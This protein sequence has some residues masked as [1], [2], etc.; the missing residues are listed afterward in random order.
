MGIGLR[1]KRAVTGALILE[2]PGDKGVA[3]A[4]ALAA[5]LRSVLAEEE[6]VRVTK[7]IKTSD[8]RIADLDESVIL[9]DVATAIAGC[10]E[11]DPLAIKVG[12]IRSAPKG[13]GTA[14]A[15]AP[16]NVANKVAQAGKIRVDWITTRVVLLEVRSLQ[17]YRCLERGHVRA[18]CKNAVD[19]SG[20]C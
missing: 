8:M 4:D 19:R 1:T 10:G 9:Q 14:W 2:V 16:V 17:C 11:C 13:L 7:P 15:R 3:E 5:K 18:T 12:P 6:G 20:L